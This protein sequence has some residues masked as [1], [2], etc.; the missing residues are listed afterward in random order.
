MDK[1]L[2]G[3]VIAFLPLTLRYFEMFILQKIAIIMMIL[4]LSPNSGNCK[5][6]N[7]SRTPQPSFKIRSTAA[8]DYMWCPGL[9]LIAN[10]HPKI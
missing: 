9:V 3:Y 4:E 6:H 10:V 1:G 2:L 8:T 5:W 7:S